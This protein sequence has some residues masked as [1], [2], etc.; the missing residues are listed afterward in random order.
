MPND[1]LIQDLKTTRANIEKGWVQGTFA[2][3]EDGTNC[4]TDDPA[5]CRFCLAGA[6]RNTISVD[7]VDHVLDWNRWNRL[8][9]VLV[10]AIGNRSIVSFNDTIGRKQ[11]DI[12]AAIDKAIQYAQP[13][14]SCLS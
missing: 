3:R 9:D 5:A 7:H 14:V 8:V 1:Q 13:D 2:Q 10:V 4:G 11:E 12:L 6:A